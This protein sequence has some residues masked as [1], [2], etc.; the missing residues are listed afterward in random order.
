MNKRLRL[1]LILGSL[2]IVGFFLIPTIS[3]YWFTDQKLKDV[4]TSSM[5]QLR[6]YSQ[7]KAA[8]SFKELLT[9]LKEPYNN[10]NI[11]N[12]VAFA[13]NLQEAKNPLYTFLKDK[14]QD[15]TKSLLTAYRVKE[16][17][18]NDLVASL[19]KDLNLV[20]AGN[21]FYDPIIFKNVP[22]I[23]PVRA[24]ADENYAKTEFAPGAYLQLNKIILEDAFPGEL[25]SSPLPD[26]YAFLGKKINQYYGIAKKALPAKY[27]ITSAFQSFTGEKA[28]TS[29]MEE[30]FKQEVLALKTKRSDA[31]QLGLDLVGGI[32][33]TIKADFETLA[34]DTKQDVAAIDKE[35]SMKRVLEILNS[36]IDQFGVTEPQIRKQGTDRII[37]EL[38]GLADPERI[39]KVILGKGRLNFHIV[40]DAGKDALDKYMQANPNNFLAADGKTLKDPTILPKGDLLLPVVAK[41]DYQLDYTIGWAVVK[42]EPALAGEYVESASVQFDPQM[43]MKPNVTFRLSALGGEKFYKVTT[44]NV[45]K[46]LAVVLDDKV[47]FQATIDEPIRSDVQV[48]GQGISQEEA[49][50]LALLLR[51]GSL[52]VPLEII[53]QE[54]VGASLGED[55]IKQ[56]LN[57]A[58]FGSLL[59]IV[60]MF[61]YYKGGGINANIALLLNVPLIAGILSVFNYTLSMPGIAGFV[62]NIGMAVDAN[63]IIFER[64]KEEFR[65]GKSRTAAIKA[66]FGKATVTIFD[67]NLTTIFAAIALGIF[68]KGPVQGFAVM[69]IVGI[70]CSM[71]TAVFISRLLYDFVT[72]T[73]KPERISLSWRRI[74]G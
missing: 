17:P 11:V 68:G 62:L 38:P 4:S 45:K 31:I 46:T 43:G 61:G 48:R 23:K 49:N 73:F 20:L 42:E 8:D 63:V 57:A 7:K 26:Q 71:F 6:D 19:V 14:L 37:I 56:G 30:A 29:F 35:E 21:V 16:E 44:D 59:V 24:N 40:D 36:R 55:A 69:L 60:F 41:D 67:A 12:K 5:T 28:F 58:L 39:R 27:T 33:V 32:R 25:S 15:Q 72:D 65:A 34:K 1:L 54:S 66:G 10:S 3:W 18:S 51:T 64:I 22:L 53:A 47:K 74:T 52:P 13:T 2:A 9:L 50:D 70:A